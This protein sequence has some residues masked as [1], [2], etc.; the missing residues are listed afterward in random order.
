MSE[1]IK[2]PFDDASGQGFLQWFKSEGGFPLNVQSVVPAG[3]DLHTAIPVGMGF[4]VVRSTVAGAGIRIPNAPIGSIFGAFNLDQSNHYN[5]WPNSETVTID[6]VNLAPGAPD[7]L[8]GGHVL[9]LI[10]I[11]NT[12]WAPLYL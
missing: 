3:T 2:N 4:V 12:E 7:S 9:L 10:R 5:V 1:H 11:S 6:P 8:G